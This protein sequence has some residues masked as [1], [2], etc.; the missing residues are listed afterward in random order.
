[1]TLTRRG[2]LAAALGPAAALGFGAGLPASAQQGPPPGREEPARSPAPA[3]APAALPEL[4]T[5]TS[6]HEV[7]VAGG[8]RLAY[9]AEAGTLAVPEPPAP[10]VGRMFYV[11]YTL[12]GAEPGTRPVSFVLNGGPGAASA[13]L[14]LGGLGPRRAAFG[15]DGAVPPPP[16]R[17]LANAETWL[18][19]TDLVFVDPVGTGYS[20]GL[21]GEGEGRGSEAFWAR[22]ADLR[23]LGAFIRRFLTGHGRWR[24]PKLVVGESYGGFRAAALAARLPEEYGV[25]L[26]GVV[27]VSPALE[28]SLLDGD[29]YEPLPGAP[30]ALL[31]RG[32]ARPR[33]PAARGGRGG[34]AGR[35]RGRSRWAKLLPGWRAGRPRARGRQ[36]PLRELRPPRPGCRWRSWRGHRG[37][38]RPSGSRRSCCATGAGS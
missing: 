19:F 20:R 7:E 4:A 6:R 34:P 23:S 33:A 25:E 22:G 9:V 2:A 8:R 38:C 15:P 32:G 10:P 1:V 28:L 37:A 11:A 27:L 26:S 35:G 17:L 3:N 12:D 36:R 31:R 14:H 18:A 13:F 30:G 5:A 21:P 29:N 24:S 16:A